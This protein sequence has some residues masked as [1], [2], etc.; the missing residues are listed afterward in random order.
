VEC[1]ERCRDVILARQLD[2]MASPGPVH[3]DVI[4]FQPSGNEQGAVGVIG[5]FPCQGVSQAGYELGLDD[6]RSSLLTHYFRIFDTL[7]NPTFLLLENIGNLRSKALSEVFAFVVKECQKR[8]M[9]LKWATVTGK[10]CG[11][12]A[13]ISA[14]LFE[15]YRERIFLYMYTP[16]CALFRNGRPLHEMRPC[17]MINDALQPW[18]KLIQPPVTRWLSRTQDAEEK[19]RLEALGN[20]VVPQCARLAIHLIKQGIKIE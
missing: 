11:L 7:A 19:M 10:Q 2:L 9:D 20:A 12:H 6:P 4:T 17:D 18:L 15:M 13:W 3:R 1:N 5:G 14:M 16:G 8:N